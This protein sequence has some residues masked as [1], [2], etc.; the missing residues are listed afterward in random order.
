M[1]SQNTL[2]C[3]PLNGILDNPEVI[4]LDGIMNTYKNFVNQCLFDG[5]TYFTPLL[6]ETMKLA[7][8]CRDQG[9]DNY[10]ILLILTD[11]EIHDMKTTIDAIIASSHL[12]LSIIIIGVGN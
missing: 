4:G 9:S 7:T 5:P 6:N 12:P 8:K 1:N 2:H 3:F 11:G 10:F